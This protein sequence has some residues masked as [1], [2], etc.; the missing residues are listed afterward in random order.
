MQYTGVSWRPYYLVMHKVHHEF[1][2]NIFALTEEVK[3]IYVLAASELAIT[4]T[5]TWSQLLAQE[6]LLILEYAGDL[7]VSDLA[8]IKLENILYIYALNDNCEVI[9]I[10]ADSNLITFKLTTEGSS[11]M[12][13]VFNLPSCSCIHAYNSPTVA[14]VCYGL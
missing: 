13:I 6:E 4:G 10:E 3:A 5:A 1:I 9:K 2:M 7:K 11:I 14:S 12:L 8:T